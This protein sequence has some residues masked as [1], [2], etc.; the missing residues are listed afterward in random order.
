MSVPE[1]ARP[2]RANIAPFPHHWLAADANIKN[3]GNTVFK[4]PPSSVKISATRC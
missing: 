3:P 2:G 4:V 1:S